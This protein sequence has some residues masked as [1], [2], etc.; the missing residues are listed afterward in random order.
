M[1]LSFSLLLYEPHR[2]PESLPLTLYHC[3]LMPPV[4]IRGGGSL[5][6]LLGAGDDV[7]AHVAGDSPPYSDQE[8][9]RVNSLP[10]GP[11][12][13]FMSLE[14]LSGPPYLQGS[15]RGVR[16]DVSKA[17][18]GPLRIIYDITCRSQTLSVR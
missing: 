3:L 12:S 5:L 11:P 9:R 13:S 2:G 10:I 14:E 18:G 16:R 17:V 4:L 7:T 6:Y 15:A 1:K 8:T